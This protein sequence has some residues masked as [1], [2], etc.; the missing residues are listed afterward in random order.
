MIPRNSEISEFLDLRNEDPWIFV[1]K[2]FALRSE[3]LRAR[4]SALGARLGEG[5]LGSRSLWV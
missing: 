3:D 2:I 4:R 5:V 1:P